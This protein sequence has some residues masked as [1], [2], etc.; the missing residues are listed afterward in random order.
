MF[1]IFVVTQS[2]VILYELCRLVITLPGCTII[3]RKLVLV[4]KQNVSALMS[5]THA[6]RSSY[7]ASGI[8]ASALPVC[9]AK[10]ATCPQFKI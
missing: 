7:H 3:L 2:P 9:N 1:H 5:S 4:L 8:G 10:T 6:E